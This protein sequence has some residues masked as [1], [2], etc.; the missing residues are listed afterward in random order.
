[1]TT[2]LA[3]L[4]TLGL[5]IVVH[6]LGHYTAARW[7]G[8]RVLRFSVGFGRP[9]LTRMDRRGTEW[10]LAAIPLGGFVKMLDEREET[11]ATEALPYAFN[12]QTLGKRI[13]IVAGGPLANL[14]LAIIL[15]WGL[16]LHG[17][18]TVRPM[19][20]DPPV[21]TAAAHAGITSGEIVLSLNDV[22]VAD[23]QDLAIRL[24]DSPSGTPIQLET[25]GLNGYRHSRVLTAEALEQARR[26]DE[27]L[28][29]LGLTPGHPE[30]PPV[31][32]K[33]IPN[34]AAARAGLQSKDRI[35]VSDGLAVRAWNDLVKDVREHPNKDLAWEI[36]RNGERLMLRIRPDQFDENS[37]K[38][39][40]IGAMPQIDP[41]VLERVRHEMRFGFFEAGQR[42]VSQTWNLSVFSLKMLGRMLL[43]EASLKN[44]SGPLTIADYAGQSAQAGFIAYTGFL[45]LISISLAVLNLLPIPLLDGG[46]LL[47]YL[48]E[49]VRRKP[50]SERVQ[51]VAQRAGMAVLLTLML[52][53]FYNDLIRLLER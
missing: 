49:W 26:A 30:L 8:V 10:T 19:L 12:R 20:G 27:P 16:Y 24:L 6:E 51:A 47:Y 31:I 25:E 15:L 43:G 4:V 40:R 41:V 35:L 34:G 22:P 45:A 2:L 46:H 17:V 18:P 32:G 21:A 29:T 7:A 53:A 39:G 3:F 14:L 42:A 28:S 13:L 50:V 5:L 23:W 48:V 38:I 36:D 33:L 52:F 9:L 11:V 37:Q 1:M 44:L